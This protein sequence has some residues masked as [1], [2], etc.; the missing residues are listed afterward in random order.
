MSGQVDRQFCRDPSDPLFF[1]L[2]PVRPGPDGSKILALCR[3]WNWDAEL[4]EIGISLYSTKLPPKVS[5]A[6]EVIKRI[7]GDRRVGIDAFNSLV[8]RICRRYRVNFRHIDGLLIYGGFF[9]VR[10]RD[11]Y[12]PALSTDTSAVRDKAMAMAR[13]NGLSEAQAEVE[14][15]IK[16][17]GFF[18]KGNG[19]ARTYR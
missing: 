18:K 15:M 8:M 7:V 5:V 2:R 4:H 11:W 17:L 16:E 13:R 10:N 6:R 19:Y 9:V 3:Y 14:V 12:E 1:I